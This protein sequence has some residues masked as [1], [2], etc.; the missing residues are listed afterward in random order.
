MTIVTDGI[1][2]LVCLEIQIKYTVSIDLLETSLNP[3]NGVLVCRDK[4][5]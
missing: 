5:V 3:Q 4:T 2:L 1:T